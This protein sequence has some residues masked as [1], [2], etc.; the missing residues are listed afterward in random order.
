[1]NLDKEA[2]SMHCYQVHGARTTLVLLLRAKP[3]WPLAMVAAT[4]A[5]AAPVAGLLPQM[6]ELAGGLGPASWPV[7]GE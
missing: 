4:P 3:V 7:F 2:T 5:R 6:P 1:M